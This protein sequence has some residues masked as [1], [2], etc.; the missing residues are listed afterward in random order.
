[1]NSSILSFPDRGFGGSS[2]Y[3]GNC[4]GRVIEALLRYLKP[5]FVVDPMEGSGTTGDVCRR[6]GIR[7]RGF[8]LRTGFDATRFALSEIL[9]GPADLVFLHPP[10]HNLIR[11]SGQVWG[12]RPHPAD[13]SQCRSLDEF[14][15]KLGVVLR[16]CFEAL[17]TWGHLAVLI[18]DLRRQGRYLPLLPAVLAALPEETLMSIVIK[19]QHH[20][21]SDAKTYSGRFI[22]IRHEYLVL[23]QRRACLP[24]ARPSRPPA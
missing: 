14:R 6:L 19:A 3:P 17:G 9:D 13:L 21:A 1:M 23:F 12:D 5:R 2:R 10:Y 22:P 15:G 8:D 11:Y 20:L 16:S 24:D 4:S 7:Y 18:G